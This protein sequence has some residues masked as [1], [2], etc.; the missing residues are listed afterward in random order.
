ML[1]IDQPMPPKAIIVEEPEIAT[2]LS[3]FLER[4]K[5]INRRGYLVFYN[6]DIVVSTHGV[7]GPSLG[8]ILEELIQ[9]GVKVVVRYGTAGTKD[10]RVK[11]G[12]YFIPI[13]VA[14]YASSSLYQRVRGDVIHSLFPDL[15]LAYGLYKL[16]KDNGREVMYGEVFQSDDFYAEESVE[17]VVDMETGTLFLI[18]TL[19][20]VRSASLLIV[21]DY[22]GVEWMNYEEVYKRDFP[23]ILDFLLKFK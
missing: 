19:K 18:S 17:Q 15:E 11:L 3:N 12:T 8:L 23:L 16:L 10:R 21:A 5:V 22:M 1:V 9:N 4:K 14:H 13:G 2:L 20:G 6:D 7:G